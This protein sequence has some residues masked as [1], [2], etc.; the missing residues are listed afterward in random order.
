MASVTFEALLDGAWQAAA[1]LEFPEEFAGDQA[2]S[3]FEYAY[4]YLDRWVGTTR[5]DVGTSVTLPLEFGPASLPTWPAFLDDLRPMGSARRWWLD[6][7]NL[8]D[9]LASD[10]R[11]LQQGTVA[12]VGNLRIAEA[13]PPKTETPRRFAAQQVIDREQGFIAW[14]ADHGAQVG[15]ATGAGGDSPKLLLRREADQVWID[16]WQDE[17]E[18]QAAHVLVK[19]ARSR[20]ERDQLIL[21]SEYVF[22]RALTRLGVAT[23]S[24][25]GLELHEGEAGPSLW[26]PR[27]DVRRHEGR[28]VRL[29]VE[30]MFSLLGAR[31][32]AR[33]RHQDVLRALR[34]LVPAADWPRL[35]L[36]YV[37]RDVLNLVFGNSDNHGRNTA[38]L[39]SAD[40]VW[41]APV[42]DFAPMKMDLE[43]ITRTTQW[44][45][46]EK[47]GEV[48]WRGLLPTFG[49]NEG[50]VRAGLRELAERLVTLPALLRELGLPRE[51]LEFP[52]LGLN[53]TEARLRTWGL[54]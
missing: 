5:F 25:E 3:Y 39:K 16:V 13:V 33:L 48:D 28:E 40:S 17:P 14:A 46:F 19:F 30:S 10:F 18:S 52:A 41:L 53:Q 42:Y 51:T 34:T 23:I 27:F 36:E 43:G 29:G 38:L 7:L 47:G 11:L 1:T 54:L 4:E 45:D 8:A 22:Y 31:P 50:F 49:E 20:R 6:R 26:L 32:G 35:L 2:R 21:R 37:Q 24:E 44:R 9:A 12:P 15:G